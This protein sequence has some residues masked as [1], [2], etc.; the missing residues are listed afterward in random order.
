MDYVV[1][2]NPKKECNELTLHKS[3]LLR[4]VGG[5]GRHLSIAL[6]DILR[7]YWCVLV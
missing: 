3:V 7:E 6:L 1:K 4:V 2:Y 5:M